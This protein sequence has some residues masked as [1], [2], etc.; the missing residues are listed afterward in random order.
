MTRPRLPRTHDP[1]DKVH[2]SLSARPQPAPGL[3][4]GLAHPPPPSR[5]AGAALAAALCPAAGPAAEAPREPS[6]KVGHQ[7]RPGPLGGGA[8]GPTGQREREAAAQRRWQRRG[9]S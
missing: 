8:G 1:A 7:E 5:G 3:G 4:A 9:D 6:G 2:N